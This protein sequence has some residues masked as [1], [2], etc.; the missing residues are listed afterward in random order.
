MISILIPTYNYKTVPMVTELH[1]QCTVENIAFEIIVLDD[2]ST[3]E[4]IVSQNLKN[5][6]MTN[7][8]FERNQTNLGRTKTRELLSQK[9]KF[10]QLLF[11]DA[12]VFPGT[13][14]FIKNY[15]DVLN[16]NAIVFGGYQYENQRPEDAKILRY[17][18]GK[19]SEEKT[20]SVRSKNPFQYIFSGNFLITKN[21]FAENNFQGIGKYYG[22]DPFFAYQLMINGKKVIHI[23][24]AVYHL[25][26]DQ[27]EVYFKKSME[28]IDVR[29]ELMVN[30]KDMAKI[31]QMTRYYLTL[32]KYKVLPIVSFSFY[33][34]GPVLKKM[35]LN[36][37][38]SMLCFKIYK[39]GYLCSAKSIANV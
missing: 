32:K 3:D 37:N 38:P 34:F 9:A 22:L 27:N 33:L 31:N 23:D 11:L 25:G 6:A 36:N 5:S 8:V 2:A 15:L 28:A 20:A 16:E 24:N 30:L 35:T 14:K 10:D 12:D 17:V 18:Y 4:E 26:L 7:C 13:S 29:R 1:N 21:D 39:L 19:T